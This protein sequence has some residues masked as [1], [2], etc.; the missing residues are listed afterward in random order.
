[1][2]MEND[3]SF[4]FDFQV[5]DDSFLGKVIEAASEATQE[6]LLNSL[7]KADPVQGRSGRKVETIPDDEIDKLLEKFEI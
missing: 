4:V 6:A 2:S 5:V 1:M 7:L 3:G